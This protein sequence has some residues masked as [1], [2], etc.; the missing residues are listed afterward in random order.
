MIKEIALYNLPFYFHIILVPRSIP[1][2][3]PKALNYALEYSC[4]EYLV[5]YDAA[6]KPEP[7]NLL[8]ALTTFRSLSDEYVCLQDKLNFYNENENI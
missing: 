3:K 5:V 7:E 4:G 2:T 1:R 8:K 6:D